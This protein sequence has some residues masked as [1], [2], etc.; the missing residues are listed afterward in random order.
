MLAVLECELTH[1]RST[2]CSAQSAIVILIAN[3]LTISQ[4]RVSS[5]LQSDATLIDEGMRRF[6]QRLQDARD[7]PNVTEVYIACCR[8]RSRADRAVA[9]YAAW[10]LSHSLVEDVISTGLNLDDSFSTFH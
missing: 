7:D 10:T 2:A 3:N 9:Q 5:H 6:K 1:R 4:H 8:L